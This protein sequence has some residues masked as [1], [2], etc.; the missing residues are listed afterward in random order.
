M[1][2][3][4]ALFVHVLQVGIFSLSQFYGGSLGGAIVSFSLLARL[5]LLPLTVGLHRRARAHSRRLKAV[6]PEVLRVRDRWKDDPGRMVAETE[7]AYRRHGLRPLD[8]SLLKGSL[9]QMPLFMGLFHSIRDVLATSGVGQSFLWVKNLASPDLGVAAI[10]VGLVG[11]GSAAGASPSQ[12]G[13]AL[14]VPM[15]ITLVMLLKMSAG[16]GLY[17]GASAMVTTLQGLIVR[18]AEA[19]QAGLE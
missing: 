1:S 10:V 17:I 16:F 2:G 7:A 6:Q 4:W 14:L 19:I 12:S 9:V 8:P 15:V 13:W 18:R 3:L 5:A 11:L